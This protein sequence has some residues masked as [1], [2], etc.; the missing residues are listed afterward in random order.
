MQTR[1]FFVWTEK[2]RPQTIAD[3]ILPSALTHTLTGILTKQDTP[4]LLFSGTAGIGKTTVALALA[5]QL[6]A[7]AMV[8]NASEENGIDVL[9]TKIRDFASSMS[10]SGNRKIVILDEADYLSAATQPALRAFTEE[11]AKGTGFIFTCNNK[12]RIIPALQSRTSAVEFKIPSAEKQALMGAYAKRAADIL[13]AE[14]VKFDQKVV[15]QVV[16]NYFPDFRRILN[17]LQRFSI[18][19]ELS[20]AILSQLSE[21][22]IKDLFDSLKKKDFG[23][24]RKW[25]V[26][27][28]DMD[29][30]AFY[31][32][33]SEQVPNRIAPECVSESII[34][35]A[36]YAF[37]SGFSADK[38]LNALAVLLELMKGGTWK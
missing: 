35:M 17:E 37:R 2:Y 6:D 10:L 27:H 13:N 33:L 31:R 34:L 16:L 36:D 15:N 19:G 4:N 3:C 5:R 28:E 11:F 25:L 26:N 1:D 22:D 14:S 29:D 23:A 24:L 20:D 7:D 38:Q 30:T 18:T 8:I 9:R 32:M 21:K 12:H